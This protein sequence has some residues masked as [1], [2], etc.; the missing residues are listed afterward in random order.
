MRFFSRLLVFALFLATLSA[1]QAAERVLQIVAPAD[2]SVGGSASLL[3]AA[4]TNT[5][6]GEHLGFLHAEYSIDDGKTWKILFYETDLGETFSRRVDV[7]VAPTKSKTIV[8]ARAAF[9]G[10]AAG[11]V[12]YA[13]AAIKWDGT[14]AQWRTPPTR[15]AVIY[16]GG[17]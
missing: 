8:R 3:I 1:T 9:R 12:D 16:V 15:Y 5:G 2:A 14:W 11:D 6:G 17:R 7:A 13:G 10:G 4:S